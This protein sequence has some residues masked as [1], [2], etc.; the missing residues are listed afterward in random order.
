MPR[1]AACWRCSPLAFLATRRRWDDAAPTP[2][3]GAHVTALSALRDPLVRLQMA[4]FFVY[5]GLE[6]GAGQWAADD[7]RRARRRA[8]RGARPR[9]PLFWAGL[10]A[11]RGSRLGFVVDRIG[12]DRLLR[13]AMPPWSAAA[14]LLATGAADLSRW[15]CWR[16][17]WRRVYP[18]LMAQTPARL[19]GP[20]AVHAIGFQV[21]AATAGVAVLPGLMGVAADA[22]GMA[23]V[24]AC[25]L[26]LAV[27]LGLL[28]RRLPPTK[29]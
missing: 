12:P 6:A 2:P 15:P 3:R 5:T 29:R 1:W 16:R 20:L 10:A 19:G 18:T 22:L 13:L 25:I 8:R 9:P 21:A 4:V 26:G 7:P 17:R 27:L 14:A 28:L 11:A 24:P 23:T